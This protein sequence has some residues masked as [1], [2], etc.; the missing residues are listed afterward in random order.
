M[1][2]VF[3]DPSGQQHTLEGPEGS[4]RDEAFK[5]LQGQL[6]GQQQKQP[7][8]DSYQSKLTAAMNTA[9]KA[10]APSWEHNKPGYNPLKPADPKNMPND[11]VNPVGTDAQMAAALGGSQVAGG[12]MGGLAAMSRLPP[13]PQPAPPP[14]PQQPV[15][16]G[17]M[18]TQ[19]GI[20]NRTGMGGQAPPSSPIGGAP[21]PAG[22]GGAGNALQ[23]KLLQSGL[24]EKAGEGLGHMLGGPV[25]GAIGRYAGRYAPKILGM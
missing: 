7:A 24:A 4:T 14:P 17:Q 10:L 22:A 25:G 19:Q 2:H 21:P 6:G 13:R 23:D 18:P 3:T 9:M 16:M 8:D 1:K 11:A 12:A 20:Q 15:N 5:V